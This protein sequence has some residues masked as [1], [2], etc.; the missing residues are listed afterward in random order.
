MQQK[1]ECLID[2]NVILRFLLN[3]VAEQAEKAKRL[4]EDIETGVEKVY[5]TDLVISEC[6]W[7]LEKFYKVPRKEIKDSLKPIITFQGVNTQSS[8]SKLLE[9][10]D[11]WEEREV[12][13]TDALLTVCCLREGREIIS[14]DKDFDKL[15][16]VRRL[17]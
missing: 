6:I 1:R 7:V 2:T 11:L 5:L 14:F 4:F 15:G 16:V 3:D 9:A 12:D 17:R 8:K 13:W 10:L